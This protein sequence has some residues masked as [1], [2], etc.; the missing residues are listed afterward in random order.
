MIHCVVM[1]T[2]I[3]RFVW[4]IGHISQPSR[5]GGGWVM[6]G[7]HVVGLKKKKKNISYLFVGLCWL[8]DKEHFKS[9]CLL[10]ILFDS[11]YYTKDDLPLQNLAQ[12]ISYPTI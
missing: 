1:K 12:I 9:Y 10:V 11:A 6:F 5:L 7:E 4:K 3:R 8:V 2:D